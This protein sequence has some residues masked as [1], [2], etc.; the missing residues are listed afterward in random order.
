[1][2]AASASAQIVPN[3]RW[4]TI[5]TKHFRIHFAPPLEEMARRTAPHAERA[6]ELL[7]RELVAPHGKVDLVIADNVDYTNGYA[8]PF[9]SNRIVIFAHPP[10]D[11]VALRNYAD[12]SELVVTHELTHIFHL[13]RAEGWW[14][15]GRYVLGRHPFFFPNA[16]MPSWVSEGLAVYYESRL[17]GT[18]RLEGS[19]HY[20]LAHAAAEAGSFP[21]L[22]EI[23]GATSR[24]PGGEVV[25]AYGGFIFDYLSQTH[26]PQSIPHFIDVTSRSIFPITLNGKAKK[27]F[28]ISFE[29]AWKSWTD[30]IIRTTQRNPEP[31]PGW[32]LLTP[33]GWLV[34]PPR[35]LSDTTILY[36]AATARDVP[37][38][39]SVA[40]SGREQK[41]GRRNAAAVNVPLSNGDILFSQPD[42]IDPFR[43]RNDLY[44]QR[45]NRQIRLT[46]GARVSA[47]DVRSNG[48]IV[49]VQ[50]VP[51][52]TRLVRISPDG[53]RILPITRG[54]LDEQWLQP[55][56]SPDGSR[57]A[58]VR[59]PPGNRAEVVV[60]DTAG[61][62]VFSRAFANAVP[63]S[64]SWS[65]DG[66]RIFFSSDH[67]GRMQIYSIDVPEGV[68]AR[69]SSAVTGMFDPE[70]SPGAQWLAATLYKTDG[71]HLGVA[72]LAGAMHPIP[73]TV[74]VGERPS[75]TTCRIADA[76]VYER[77][78]PSAAAAHSY[79][80]WRS[81]LPTY[82]E[83]VIESTVGAGTKL[84]AT[85]SGEDVIGIHSYLT[86]ATYNTKFSEA[87]GFFA[88]RYAGFGQP[89]LNMS[90]EQSWDHFDVLNTED[91]VVGDFAQRARIYAAS[92]SFSRPRVRTS[93]SFTVGGELETRGYSTDPDT[94]LQHLSEIY[95][96]SARYPSVVASA[97]WTNTRIPPLAISRE[98]GIT[99]SATA[100]E[101]WRTGSG[102]GAVSSAPSHT[103]IGVLSGYK[104]LDLP[105]F[106]H[107]VIAVRGAAGYTDGQTI[108]LL[109]AGGLSGSSLDVLA[110]YGFGGERR[111]F[112][113][114]GF[115]PSAERGIRAF[116][117]SLEY[118]APLAAPSRH[119]RFIP[120]L[121][122]RI[123]ASAFA[124][125]GRAYC[126]ASS[127]NTSTL[128]AP[129]E[130]DNPWL[131]SV[132]AE[133]NLDAA[134][135]YDIPA[136]I[137]LGVVAPI[138]GRDATNAKRVSGYL[139]FGT[140]F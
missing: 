39:Y 140:S 32:R 35:W 122:D 43:L 46:H 106:A 121:F 5:E 87:E 111:P 112:G 107:H 127:V 125:A 134:L 26:G 101:R 21:S 92:L 13:S 60:I 41:I 96:E 91:K 38:A 57:I 70:A 66:R 44:V 2:S 52:S 23:S 67:S 6:F 120:L 28:G 50:N 45:G 135:Y 61:S 115:A 68:S 95:R 12:W 94:L 16:F 98:D 89:Y 116:A 139:T 90:A 49:A 83:P 18:G 42:F 79:S 126:P 117:G 7:S 69:L 17:T 31:I 14:K 76:Q 33:E 25:Y 20:M 73:D 81:L 58:A 86:Q 74:I 53:K 71:F 93:A 36:G 113:V 9:P 34:A 27:A 72:P 78:A 24:F 110:G 129:T 103:V 132:G 105:G 119:I 118:R 55:R 10:V 82:W 3:E 63:A 84:G 85:T 136:R 109:S 1:M 29:R 59:L 40:L 54:S 124:D 48:D 133:L 15:V 99:L 97:V 114:R 137:R 30:S 100:R 64:P 123:S 138:A 65:A 77:A 37:H 62:I 130:A 102:D 131:A 4:R 75:C 104:S 128:C 51:G 19:E 80:P 47:P 88:Y 22:N 11:E 56:W 108:S 8:T